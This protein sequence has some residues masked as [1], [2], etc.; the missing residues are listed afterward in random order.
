MSGIF[1]APMEH[2]PMSVQVGT[3]ELGRPIYRTVLG[4]IV[5]D[6]MQGQAPENRL[7]RILRTEL[8]P[9]GRSIHRIE[10]LQPTR[11]GNALAS[12][13][14]G[15]LQG[16]TAPG[17]AARGEAVTLGDVWATALDN[18][19]IAAP[20]PAPRGAIRAGAM[21]SQSPADE[22]AAML[23][24]G[25]AADITD[26]MMARLTPEDNVNLFRL[27][28]EGATGQPMPMDEASRMARAREMGFGENVYHGTVTRDD[29][30]SLGQSAF[31]RRRESYVAPERHRDY[32]SSYAAGD[33]GRVLSMMVDRSG[34]HDGRT[35]GGRDALIDLAYER[36]FQPELYSGHLRGD[37]STLRPVAWG[38]QRSI[39]ELNRAGYP[40]AVI[41]ER[42]WM[43]SYAIFDPTRV[44]SRFAR[45]DPR[46]S[47]LA[48]LSAGGA[49]VAVLG[50][51]DGEASGWESARQYLREIGAL[52]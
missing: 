10:E 52:E 39:D 47:H 5:G 35:R 19:A 44:R 17:R 21:A 32:A 45:F 37:A 2:G 42:P 22:I 1:D 23:R 7:A 41:E 34:F 25:R 11:T 16:F 33:Q 18:G 4:N 24:S 3:D 13:A 12:L 49:G 15:I 30:H 26:D 6:A 51:Q 43:D 27:Y 31:S 14:Q 50:G 29:F 36:D 48:H 20:M 28:E 8:D 40:G 46:L 38:D 9:Q